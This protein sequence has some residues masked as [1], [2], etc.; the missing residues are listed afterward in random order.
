[1][2]QH[3]CHY[4]DHN[5][6]QCDLEAGQSGL[7]FWHDPTSSKEGDEIASQLQQVAS[8]GHSL[9]GFSLRRANLRGI[10]LVKKGSR[11]GYNLTYVDLYHADLSEA[12]LFGADLRH[13]SLMKADLCGAN[14][15]LSNLKDA[16]LLGIKLD[17][18]KLDNVIWGDLILQEKQASAPSQRLPREQQQDYL[19]QA[20]E[21]YRTLRLETE[22]QGLFQT[23]GRFFRKE[24]TMR[25][26]QMPVYSIERNISA[27]VDLF[28]GYGELPL[29]VLSFSLIIIL[30]C[31]ILYNIIGLGDAGGYLGWQVGVGLKQNLLTLLECL[32]FSIITFTT[33]GYGDLVPVGYSRVV[34]AVEAFVGAF[35]I[36]L[37]VVV[38]VKKMT[39]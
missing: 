19:Q 34:A 20:E 8:E 4:K 6:E 26:L 7:C 5:G 28:C 25:R 36:A 1:M 32:Y 18:T 15:H 29:R 30:F 24:M 37:F 16:N 39:R 22:S 13:A 17:G 38:F 11:E 31:G 27:L 2:S 21:I 35:T 12:H 9:E 14:I 33:L 10:N 3:R 23:A